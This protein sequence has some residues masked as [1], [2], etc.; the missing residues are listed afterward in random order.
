M[1]NTCGEALQTLKVEKEL[2]MNSAV[3]HNSQRETTEN[4]AIHAEGEIEGQVADLGASMAKLF[5]S[6]RGTFNLVTD[7]F[8]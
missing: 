1:A 6:G 3:D 8:Y 2:H 5:L 7:T 4:S